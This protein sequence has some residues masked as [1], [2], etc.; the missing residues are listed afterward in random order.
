MSINKLYF[1]QFVLSKNKGS[2]SEISAW[3]IVVSLHTVLPERLLGEPNK[4]KCAL[5]KQI[6]VIKVFRHYRAMS[7]T[8]KSQWACV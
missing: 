1:D 4:L 6:C 5:F 8:E 2:L 7:E 3:E